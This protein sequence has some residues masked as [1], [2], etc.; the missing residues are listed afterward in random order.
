MKFQDIKDALQPEEATSLDEQRARASVRE[1]SVGKKILWFVGYHKL[2][3]LLTV[4]ILGLIIYACIWVSQDR[5]EKVLYVTLLNTQVEDAAAVSLFPDLLA[6]G[7]HNPVDETAQVTIL[8]LDMDSATNQTVQTYQTIYAQFLVGDFDIFAADPDTYMAFAINDGYINLRDYLTQEQLDR[9]ADI[10]F[11]TESQDSGEIYP[12][13]FHVGAESL[14]SAYYG[15][16]GCV[17]GVCVNAD[18]LD[19]GWEV[20]LRLIEKTY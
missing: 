6:E 7:D 18:N 11:Y 15:D 1:M 19:N 10:L 5:A 9:Y 4:V 8:E 20:L 13:G 16:E 12:C 3:C 17:V 2:L 14:L